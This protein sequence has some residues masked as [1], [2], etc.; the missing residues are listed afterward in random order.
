MAVHCSGISVVWCA[1]L[2]Y[3]LGAVYCHFKGMADRR[4]TG[5]TL[6]ITI[7][8]AGAIVY[9]AMTLDQLTTIAHFCAIALGLCTAG[10]HG[11]LCHRSFTGTFSERLVDD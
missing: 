8:D 9:Y 10:V 3:C 1:M 7:V 6:C 5:L 4:S 2:G 11:L